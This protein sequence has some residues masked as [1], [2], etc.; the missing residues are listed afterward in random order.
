ML[1]LKLWE[2]LL[3]LLN[4]VALYCL[5]TVNAFPSTVAP[6]MLCYK[7]GTDQVLAVKTYS[8]TV[9]KARGAR[10]EETDQELGVK[11]VHAKVRTWWRHLKD[12]TL[13]MKVE[14]FVSSKASYSFKLLC[15]QH[16]VVEKHLTL[17][18][19]WTKKMSKKITCL[20][21]SQ[22]T[23]CPIPCILTLSKLLFSISIHFYCYSSCCVLSSEL[24]T[25]LM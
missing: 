14:F 17:W 9:T 16:H 4:F 5:H 10:L 1:S 11:I 12:G 24:E 20:E 2:I 23:S 13:R 19:F 22:R 18:Y 21:M 8:K 3:L 6:L 15:L 25:A 7:L